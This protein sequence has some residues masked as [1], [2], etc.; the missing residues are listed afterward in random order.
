MPPKEDLQ[1][2]TVSRECKGLMLH[3]NPYALPEGALLEA[4]NVTIDRPNIISKTRGLNRYGDALS[5]APTTMSEFNDKIIVQDGTTLRFDSDG[6]GT[7]TALSGTHAAPDANNRMRFVE[8]LF[9]LFFTTS[10]GLFRLDD[11]VT[12][13]PARAGMPQGLDID[14][15]FTGTGLG[16]FNTAAQI[17]YKVVYIRKDANDQEIIGAPSFRQVVQNPVTAT[18]WTFA[19]PTVT[20][21]Q[22][23][24]G[25]STLDTIIVTNSSDTPT[26][27]PT[28]T[29]T[30][31]GA[32]TYTYTI[33]GSPTASGTQ[34][35]R[36]DENVDIV[37]TIPDDVAA[38]DFIEI[39]RTEQSAN[40]TTGP[41]GRYL[42]V[43]RVELASGDISTG[44]ITF[45]DTFAE[46]FLGEDL[47]DNP[48]AEGQDQSSFRA[49]HMTD[50]TLWRGHLWGCN[51][52]QPHRKQ[53]DFLETTGLMDNTSSITIGARTYI[54][55]GADDIPNQ[56]FKREILQTTEAENVAE[57]MRNLCRVA[58]RDTG[59]TIFYLRY[60]SGPNDPPGQ[61]LIE[62]RDLTDTALAFTVDASG[63]G[64]NFSPV[65][66]TSG[67]TIVTEAVQRTNRI[68]H[69]K[70]EEPDGWPLLNLDDIGSSRAKVLRLVPLRD[71]LMIFTERGVHLVTGDVEQDFTI[72]EMETD[73]QLLAVESPAVLNDKVWC[74][75][76]QGIVSLNENGAEVRSFHG[77]ERDLQKI[78]TFTNFK[79]LTWGLAYEEDHKYI[80]WTQGES[81]DATVT[82]GWFWNDFTETWVKRIKKVSCGIVPKE[83]QVMFLGHAVDTFVL[84]E[85]KSFTSSA[86]DFVDESITITITAVSTGTH[87]TTGN[88]VTELTFTYTYTGTPLTTEFGV[89]QGTDFGRILALVNN[90][91]NSFTA[92]LDNLGANWSAA[93]A[94]AE[95]PIISRIRWAPEV[96]GDP[97][98]KKQFT[99]AVLS[100]EADTARSM[101]FKFVSDAI[102]DEIAVKPIVITIALGWGSV[103]WGSAKW[104][105]SGPRRSTPRRVPIPRK[106]QKCRALSTIIEHTRARSFFDIANLGLTV[107]NISSRTNDAS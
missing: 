91:S 101:T 5:N 68:V 52:R 17:A 55:S 48:E 74:F 37:T 34:D 62:R 11:E 81:G 67:S 20:V 107:R 83:D 33:A 72:V 86:L 106:C 58:N 10:T 71:S 102:Q 42:K 13:T 24:H 41:G 32:N 22:T 44:T 92:T 104:G 28:S 40:I 63:T 19:M 85:R 26:E 25:Y 46:A 105:S 15:S 27:A 64:D 78:Q 36:R 100:L 53:L 57:T 38:G 80:L 60:I 3:P 70:F 84:K 88:T 49:P 43:N 82:V 31:T 99:Y 90:G 77:I 16:F 8:S 51:T 23:A 39:Y 93:A 12:G 95:I 66:P 69:S 29:I 6:A 1:T 45:S 50:V 76:N 56:K 61:I 94:T 73:I 21:T 7:W 47:Y 65:L 14:N 59:N 79:T 87:P 96:Y 89:S 30:S 97:S 98:K 9:S 75:T 2:Q 18:T 103:S 54:F 35:V 4:N